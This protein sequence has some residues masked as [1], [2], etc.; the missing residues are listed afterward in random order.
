[1]ENAETT[2]A[3]NRTQPLLMML[4]SGML[5]AGLVGAGS[6]VSKQRSLTRAVDSA[7]VGSAILGQNNR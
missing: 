7:E 1:M 5:I 2:I 3:H 4:L 6:Y